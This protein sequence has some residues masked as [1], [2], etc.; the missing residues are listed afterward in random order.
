MNKINFFKGSILAF[1]L[2][3]NAAF[4]QRIVAVYNG[5]FQ[6]NYEFETEGGISYFFEEVPEALIKQYE[7]NTSTSE[8]VVFELTYKIQED[9]DGDDIYIL[10]TLKPAEEEEFEIEEDDEN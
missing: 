2:N 5:F 4:S 7:L 10:K 1:L 6:H 9:L 3:S 8:G